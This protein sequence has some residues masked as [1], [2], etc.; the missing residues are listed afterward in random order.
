MGDDEQQVTP[1]G[2]TLEDVH[3]DIEAALFATSDLGPSEFGG[4]LRLKALIATNL[5]WDEWW[6]IGRPVHGLASKPDGWEG[7]PWRI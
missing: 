3:D 4:D 6:R 5:S 1:Q 7:R 2:K